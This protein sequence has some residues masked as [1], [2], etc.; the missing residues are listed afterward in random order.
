MGE[1]L[2]D[3]FCQKA[4]SN[5]K[6]LYLLLT[7]L[8]KPDMSYLFATSA[9]YDNGNGG[10]DVGDKSKDKDKDKGNANSN[11][12]EA[13]LEDSPDPESTFPPCPALG[14]FTPASTLCSLSGGK[15]LLVNSLIFETSCRVLERSIHPRQGACSSSLLSSFSFFNLTFSIL[16]FSS[17]LTSTFLSFHTSISLFLSFPFLPFR[18][19]Q[20]RMWT[21]A[22]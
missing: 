20:R 3:Y 12:Q 1:F 17:C 14:A 19:T 13:V 4:E 5:L 16:P 2:D 9:N 18:S 7:G 8:V 21:R 22:I 6:R 10:S 11:N 15:G